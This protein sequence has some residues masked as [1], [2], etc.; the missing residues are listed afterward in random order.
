MSMNARTFKTKP[1]YS[2]E[3]RQTSVPPPAKL[4]SLLQ[5]PVLAVH[6]SFAFERI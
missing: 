5:V 2:S 4:E 6:A 3:Y 1:P